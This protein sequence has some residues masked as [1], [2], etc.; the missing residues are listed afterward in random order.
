[1]L[2]IIELA[3]ALELAGGVP[4]LHPERK[5]QLNRSPLKNW[6]EKNGGLPTYIN[7]VATALLREHPEWGIS[8]IIAT[9]VNWAKKAC[10]TGRAF[11]GRVKVSKAVQAAACTAVAQWERK[12]AAASNDAIDDAIIEA[13]EENSISYIHAQ[14][15]KAYRSKSMLIPEVLELSDVEYIVHALNEE[16]SEEIGEGDVN[17]VDAFMQ[18]ME[19]SAAA[20]SAVRLPL[21]L[22]EMTKVGDRYKKEI[23][24]VG[25]IVVD[26][27]TGRKFD[28]TPRFLRQLKTNFE[29]GVMD[30]VPLL[31]TDDNNRHVKNGAPGS[32][33]GFVEELSLDDEDNP[34]KLFGTFNLTED[35]RRMVEHNPKYAVSVTAHPNFVDLSKGEYHGPLLMNV[36]GTHDG[37][38]KKL[39][40]W[41]RL[42]VNASNG[43]EDFD[44]IDL[45]NAEYIEITGGDEMP[46]TV[47][48]SNE[49]RTELFNEFMQSDAFKS[50]LE[51]AT[52]AKDAQIAEL[53]TQVSGMADTNYNALVTATTDRYRD[54]GVPP[55]LVDM[56]KELMLSFTL[57]ERNTEIELS[58]GEG[59][60]ATTEKLPRIALVT[61]MLDECKGLIKLSAEE[62]SQEEPTE[63]ELSQEKH[64]A[65]AQ[66]LASQIV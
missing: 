46:E 64:D 9:A 52:Q 45:S 41:E 54:A 16:L 51:A 31:F 21:N 66:W 29:K 50:A 14:G 63:A 34:T 3:G 26:H 8:R 30:Y 62:G 59:D 11:G 23:L 6:V 19:L 12:K 22:S 49:Q 65:G 37:K 58:I 55:V 40:P 57:D 10:S 48:L 25:E 43:E 44:V 56:A 60:S 33:G 35:T 4:A 17:N 2:D 7:S 32:Y 1:M 47:E 28:F 18:V 5:G 36:A 39:S 38:L 24:K 15:R 27:N 53:S 20:Q 42:T 13:S 61:K